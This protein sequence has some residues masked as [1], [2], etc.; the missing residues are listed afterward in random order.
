MG[1]SPT[2]RPTWHEYLAL[3]EAS[4]ERLEFLDGE[5]YA[6][7]GASERHAWL[8][9]E[10]L[11]HLKTALHGRP[12]RVYGSDLLIAASATRGGLHPDVTVICGPTE[13]VEPGSRPITNP[14]LLVEVLSPATEANDRGEKFRH[15]QHIPSVQHYLLLSQ[16]QPQAELFTR[17]G[18]ARRD[19]SFGPGDAIPF[20]HLDIRL[21]VDA[22]YAGLPPVD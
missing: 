20:T 22:L 2:A 10:T 15:Y 5:V 19:Q 6:T 12:C 1:L 11:A 8:A 13:R 3:E 18:P 9:G 4:H 16:D 17:M 14:C 21:S 7:A